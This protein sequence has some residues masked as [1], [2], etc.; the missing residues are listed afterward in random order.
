M[1]SRSVANQAAAA[2]E[3]PRFHAYRWSSDKQPRTRPSRG[4]WCCEGLSAQS[5]K[6]VADNRHIANVLVSAIHKHSGGRIE[7]TQTHPASGRRPDIFHK[8]LRWRT[9]T[10]SRA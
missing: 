9:A 8:P 6:L 5:P 7:D 4:S 3:A 2:K 10:E 1:L